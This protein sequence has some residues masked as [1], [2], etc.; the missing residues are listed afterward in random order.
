MPR[1]RAGDL[2]APTS[3]DS[4]LLVSRLNRA[5]L[6]HLVASDLSLRSDRLSRTPVEVT[7]FTRRQVQ[8][9]PGAEL[10]CIEVV[11]L[12]FRQVH[13]AFGGGR[14]LWRVEWQRR[15]VE[16]WRASKKQRR[17]AYSPKNG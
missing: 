13:A 7:S 12:I 17:C 8:L 11:L 10:G 14:S 1:Q 9:H 5:R 16:A 15:P 3:S 4:E 6:E 2:K